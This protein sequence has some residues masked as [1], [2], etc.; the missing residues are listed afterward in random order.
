MKAVYLK[1]YDLIRYEQDDG[2]NIGT[3]TPDE[4]MKALDECL[5]TR[6]YKIRLDK[7]RYFAD[8]IERHQKMADTVLATDDKLQIQKCVAAKNILTQIRHIGRLLTEEELNIKNEILERKVN[9]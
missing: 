4:L 1:D 5:L 8:Y 9:K 2:T 7:L 3:M 6:L